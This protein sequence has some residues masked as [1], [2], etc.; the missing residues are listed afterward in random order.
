MNGRSLAR[1]RLGPQ[2]CLRHRKPPAAS[3]GGIAQRDPAHP[4]RRPGRPIHLSRA[5]RELSPAV[6]FWVG[7]HGMR[8]CSIRTCSQVLRK[9]SVPMRRRCPGYQATGTLILLA[10]EA[11]AAGGARRCGTP[12]F[13]DLTESLSAHLDLRRK[14]SSAAPRGDILPLGWARSLPARAASSWRQALEVAAR[15][16]ACPRWRAAG[17][18][19]LRRLSTTLASIGSASAQ[20]YA[21]LWRTAATASDGKRFIGRLAWSGVLF[22]TPVSPPAKRLS[23]WQ[24]PGC[25]HPGIAAR[26]M[27]ECAAGSPP[28]PAR[29]VG[30]REG[31]CP[32]PVHS[33]L[34]I[35]E[36]LARPA[37]AA[38]GL[39]P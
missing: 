24:G 39:S 14:C 15:P 8:A 33:H 32:A 12:S 2:R 31:T 29:Q 30:R 18:A 4:R 5:P 7:L 27:R 28:S 19:A 37:G 1:S 21:A 11:V 23:A 36:A 20:S 22:R 9:S 13:P 3:P 26:A 35:C 17:G 25:A 10:H 34:W 38:P 16:D 6:L